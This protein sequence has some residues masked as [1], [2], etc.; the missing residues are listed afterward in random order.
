MLLNIYSNLLENESFLQE[1]ESFAPFMDLFYL[2]FFK[3]FISF[4][5]TWC[6]TRY[7]LKQSPIHV[8]MVMNIVLATAMYITYLISNPSASV[9]FA[10][11]NT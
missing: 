11:K 6:R 4:Y 9:K 1:F 8:I 5:Y 10:V 7:L 3:V 2:C